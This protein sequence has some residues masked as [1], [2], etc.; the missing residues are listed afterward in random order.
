MTGTGIAGLLRLGVGLA[1]LCAGCAREGTPR[2]W[3]FYAPVPV[4]SD[5]EAVL[6]ANPL[7]PGASLRVVEIGRGES[8][9]HHLVQ[10]RDAERAHVHRAHDLTVTLVRGRGEQAVGTQRVAVAAGDVVFVPRGT[11]HFFRNI[12]SDPAVAL[13]TF[14]PPYDGT[15]HVPV[16]PLEPR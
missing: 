11:V 7:G 8:V 10:V 15:D 16:E 12:G 14:S 1:A 13:V 4:R 5:I 3:M 9:S 6:A 2:L